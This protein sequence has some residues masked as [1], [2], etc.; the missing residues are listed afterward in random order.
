MYGD[1]HATPIRRVGQS[2]R[3]ELYFIVDDNESKIE[4]T[5]DEY[6][7]IKEADGWKAEYSFFESKIIG[8]II[9]VILFSICFFLP[10]IGLIP[11]LWMAI[12]KLRKKNITIFKY[13]SMPVYVPDER[14][15]NGTRFEGY[16]MQKNQIVMPVKQKDKRALRV[17][18]LIYLFVFILIFVMYAYASVI[19]IN[20]GSFFELFK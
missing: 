12:A 8:F 5:S 3:E 7:S 17:Y 1:K 2:G 11:P 9:K 10:I 18:G 19:S 15:K 13:E 14:Y 16:A 20:D 4:Y 6:R